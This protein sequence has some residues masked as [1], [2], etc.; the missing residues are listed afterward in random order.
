[1][2]KI[3]TFL[4]IG[5][6][7]ISLIAPSIAHASIID[8][9]PFDQIKE[10]CIDGKVVNSKEDLA[11]I[12]TNID[13]HNNI[14]MVSSED[15][16]KLYVKAY[17]LTS[18]EIIESYEQNLTNKIEGNINS[19]TEL[20]EETIEKVDE[21]VQLTN[22]GYKLNLPTS[23]K[24]EMTSETYESVLN[25]I[26]NSNEFVA[27]EN[28][29]I[30]EENKE[31][32]YLVSDST[33][34]RENGEKPMLRANG[35]SKV[36]TYW[37]GYKIYMSKTFLHYAGGGITGAAGYMVSKLKLRHPIAIAAA[38]AMGMAGVLGTSAK[39]GYVVRITRVNIP[40]GPQYI[41]SGVWRQ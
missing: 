38:G 19:M 30:D 39:H 11:N 36:K 27:E 6:L 32:L 15:R 13:E 1:M 7:G 16:E 2:K 40:F 35:V 9:T 31:A 26:K 3:I 37:W 29:I 34:M 21:Y 25:S 22:E 33:L 41:V 5:V 28:V 23:V 14:S 10:E 12:I 17:S 20:D 24:N 4:I 18:P 8:A